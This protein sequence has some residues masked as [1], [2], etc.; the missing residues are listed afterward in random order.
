MRALTRALADMDVIWPAFSWVERVCSY[1]NPGDLPSWGRLDEAM[2]RFRLK[3]GGV[4]TAPTQHLQM[5]HSTASETVC[6][7]SSLSGAQPERYK[8]NARWQSQLEIVKCRFQQL[9]S[10]LRTNVVT[11][12][13]TEKQAEKEHSVTASFQ[14][15]ISCAFFSHVRFAL[16]YFDVLA[17]FAGDRMANSLHTLYTTHT[18]V[19]NGVCAHVQ[20]V[21]NIHLRCFIQDE[22]CHEVKALSLKNNWK[23]WKASK[24]FPAGVLPT[25]RK[26]TKLSSNKSPL[27]N[28]NFVC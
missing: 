16:F 24:N 18:S 7:S 23:I 13:Q 26:P 25:W 8:R 17:I 21:N 22:C 19:H 10:K 28:F 2:R 1:S 12:P 15:S 14:T 11:K 27:S 5:D 3:D 6:T 9:H 20:R 4:V